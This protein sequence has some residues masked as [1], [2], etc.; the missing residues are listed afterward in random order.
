MT[1]TPAKQKLL[2]LLVHESCLVDI[3]NPN[4]ERKN[5]MN[6]KEIKKLMVQYKAEAEAEI[7][8][9]KRIAKEA[10]S[11]SDS[12]ELGYAK[13]YAK[14]LEEMIAKVKTKRKES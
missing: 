6:I 13:G 1:W 7:P 14:A 2:F 4:Q 10:G 11:C 5:Q 3:D 9:L 12:E 8:R